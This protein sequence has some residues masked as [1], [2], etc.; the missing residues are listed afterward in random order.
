MGCLTLAYQLLFLQLLLLYSQTSATLCSYDQS[1]ALLQ[2]K[3]HFSYKN[4]LSYYYCDWARERSFQFSEIPPYCDGRCPSYRKTMSW[5]EDTDCCSWD[6]VTCDIL[7]GHVIAL[8]LS[9][10]WLHGNIP[11]NSSLFLLHH[12]QRLNLAFN[13]FKLSQ[14]S[15]DFRQLPSLTHLN[16]SNSN[17]SGKIPT[18]ISHLSNLVSLDLSVSE[19]ETA[20]FQELV[21]NLTK[22]TELRLDGVDMSTIVPSFLTNLSYSLTSLSLNDCGLQGNIPDHIFRSPNLQFLRLRGNFD[23]KGVFPKVN[24]SSPLKFMDV[25]DMSL[26][27]ELPNSIGDLMSLYHLRLYYCNMVGSIPMSLGNLTQLTYLSLSQ[28]TISVVISHH[29]C[30][31]LSS[32]VILIFQ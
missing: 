23:L 26:S 4:F 28:V 16:L 27:G 12:L 6:G 2:F 17:F 3:Q 5:K 25:S 31:I 13:D 10:G 14:V 29:F 24:W 9:C 1:I 11:S 30:Q 19:L 18:E 21:Q 7:T 15:S 22:L 8:D 20:V 32:S